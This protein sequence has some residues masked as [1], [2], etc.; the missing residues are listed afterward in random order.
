MVRVIGRSQKSDKPRM[1]TIN[2]MNK[3]M[4][5]GGGNI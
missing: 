2:M 3:V 1:S 5:G 4:G